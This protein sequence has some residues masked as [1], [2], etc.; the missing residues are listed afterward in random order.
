MRLQCHDLRLAAE[1]TT[2]VG[3][4]GGAGDRGLGLRGSRQQGGRLRRAGGEK[5]HRSC[6]FWAMT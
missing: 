2:F 5:A 1:G 4:Q 6:D 3:R